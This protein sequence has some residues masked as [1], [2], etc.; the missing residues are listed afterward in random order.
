MVCIARNGMI[1]CYANIF[2]MEHE[3]RSYL[4]EWHNYLGPCELR[5]ADFNPKKRIQTGFYDAM[6]I[7]GKMSKKQR[8]KFRVP[9]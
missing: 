3:G 1:M 4:F 9:I 6:N 8:E 5:K 2:R 7:F